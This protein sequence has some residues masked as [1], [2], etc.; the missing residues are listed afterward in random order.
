M[1]KIKYCRMGYYFDFMSNTLYMTHRFSMRAND[2]YGDEFKIYEGFKDR[3]PLLRV[4][5]EKL[6]KRNPKYIPYNKMIQYI[7]LMDDGVDKLAEFNK[8]RQSSTAQANPTQ[9]VNQWFKETFPDYKKPIK[10]AS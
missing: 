7:A 5:V 10:K 4:V 1:A 8:V 3:F 6:P 2:I 9:F